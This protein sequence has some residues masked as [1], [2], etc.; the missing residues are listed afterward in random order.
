M[1]VEIYCWLVAAMGATI[2][3]SIWIFAR[4]HY[5]ERRRRDA[6]SQEP[7]VSSEV[8]ESTHELANE[9]TKLRAGLHKMSQAPNPIAAFVSSVVSSHNH[10]H[11]NAGEHR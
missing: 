10:E 2:L 8:R 4:L 7:L 3:V 6:V 5:Y 1:K 9:T 11:R